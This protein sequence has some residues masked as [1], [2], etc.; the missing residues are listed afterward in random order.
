MSSA[1]GDGDGCEIRVVRSH[2]AFTHI[3][4]ILLSSAWPLLDTVVSEINRQKKKR[5]S[6]R[7]LLG[8]KERRDE[9]RTCVS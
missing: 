8:G 6:K 5:Q 9:V 2:T 1:A 7:K 4:R 3:L